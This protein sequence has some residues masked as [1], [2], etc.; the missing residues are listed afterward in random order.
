MLQSF[1]TQF[2]S[3]TKTMKNVYGI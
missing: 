3:Q 1:Q 2:L